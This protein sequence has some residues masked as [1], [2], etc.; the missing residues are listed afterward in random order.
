MLREAWRLPSDSTSRLGDLLL[1]LFIHTYASA[2]VF[3]VSCMD[4]RVGL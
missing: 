4:V 2:M 1:V 3:P